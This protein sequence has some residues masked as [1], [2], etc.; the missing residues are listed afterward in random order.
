[1]L[2]LTYKSTWFLT[3]RIRNAISQ[4]VD[5]VSDTIEVDK[6]WIGGKVK[7]KGRGYRGNK[8]MVIG[9]VERHGQ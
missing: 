5:L 9:L 2:G 7:G 1:M 4:Q 8:A 3:H 6:T